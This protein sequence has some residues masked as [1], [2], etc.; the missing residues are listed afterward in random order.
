MKIWMMTSAAALSAALVITSCK[1]DVEKPHIAG[2]QI[3]AHFPAPHY[4][5]PNN[6]YSNAAFQLGRHLFYDPLL[7]IDN[8]IS[9]ASCHAQNHGFA[10]HNVP[11]SFGVK[12]RMGKRNSPAIFNMIWNTSF[13]WDGGINHIEIMPLA[14]L[15]DT[16]E[17]ASNL[18]TIMRRLK[19]SEKYQGLFRN[20]FGEGQLTDQRMLHALAQFMGNLVS[21]NSRYDKYVMKKGS[22]T[23]NEVKGLNLFR[24]Y[25]ETCH[26]EPLF[27]DYSF[28]SNG[29]DMFPKDS[30]RMRIT[31]LESDRG[32]FKVP[33]LRNIAE[34]YPYMH[35][36]RFDNLNEVLNHYSGGVH[37]SANTDSRVIGI[38]L[39]ED[40]KS[41]IISFLKTLS[42]Y[43]FLSNPAFS[44]PAK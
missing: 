42:D 4:A 5:A 33:T 10:D 44:P 20:A 43:T 29:L 17:M 12:G 13:M 16:L 25:C 30:G 27:T 1:Q 36:G 8:T 34:T 19:R 9:C 26:K 3:P 11:K 35:D 15:Q 37:Q 28:A 2:P 21:G 32:K 24:Q 40:E 7:S 31:Q 6:P 23:A 14:P 39:T 38:Q 41:D 18:D 22:F